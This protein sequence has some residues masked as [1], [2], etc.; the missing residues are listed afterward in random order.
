MKKDQ[1]TKSF[2]PSPQWKVLIIFALFFIAIYMLQRYSISTSVPVRHTIAYSQFLEQLDAGNISSVTIKK[3]HIAGQFYN[4]ALIPLHKDQEPTSVKD[5]KTQ[6]PTFQGEG[7]IEK[8]RSR[9]VEIRVESSEEGSF[10]W[11]FLIGILPWV[12]IIGVWM[13]VMRGARQVGGGAG[14]LFTFGQSKATLFD[15]KKPKVTY[16]EVAGMDNVKKELTEVIEFLK[17]PGKFE[18]IGA[19][20]PKG[21]LLIGPPGTGKTLL[22]RATAGEAGVPFYSISASEFIEMFVGVGA[23]RVRD[24]FKKAKDAHPSIIFIDEIDAVG[25]TRGAGFGGGHDEREQTLNQLLSEM[26]GFDPHTEVIVM[27]A[28]NRPDVLDPALLRPGRFD[29]QLVIDKPGWKERRKILEVHVRNKKLAD[30]VDLEKIARGTPGMT[31]A[32]LENLANEAALIAVRKKKKTINNE[33]FDDARDKILMGTV[34]EEIINDLEKRITAYH[35]AGHTL[36]SI[37]LPGT[38]PIHKVSIVPRGLAMGVTQILPEEDRHYYPKQYLVNKLTVALA[39]RCAEKLIFNDV[40]TGAQND[41]KEATALAEK[42]VAQWGMSDK[43]G[44]LSLGR[45]EDHPF[46]GRELAFQKRYSE[47]M[48]WLMDQEIQKIIL[49]AEARASEILK[50]NQSSLE[51]LAEALIKEETLEKEDV[52]KILNNA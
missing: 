30:K 48:A 32:D 36:V 15:V 37:K 33:D 41:L 38:D 23:A 3:L 27:A 26:D 16:C 12:I 46:L 7:L 24:M 31:G 9:R 6:L 25:R 50:N 17:D 20:V 22:A 19:K 52:E 43:I 10:F 8:L 49:E 21:V 42:M 2:T 5:F 4:E 39:G 51:K 45:G 11:Q 14:G 13:L 18:K 34:R 47:D 1:K 44:P 40:S 35:E 28:T 29:R